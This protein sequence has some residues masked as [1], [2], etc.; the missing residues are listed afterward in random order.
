MQGAGL[1]TP[2]KPGA[3][4]LNG[5]KKSLERF[6][7][8]HDSVVAHLADKIVSTKPTTMQVYADLNGWRVNGGTLRPDLPS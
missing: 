6:E 1:W 7:F 3:P 2:I 5:Y 8:R 4:I